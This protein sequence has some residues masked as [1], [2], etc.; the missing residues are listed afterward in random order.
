MKITPLV[1]LSAL[2]FCAIAGSAQADVYS[3]VSGL[4]FTTNDVAAFH[5]LL[6]TQQIV[7]Q[8]ILALASRE[9]TAQPTAMADTQSLDAADF[10]V[11]SDYQILSASGDANLQLVGRIDFSGRGIPTE[12]FVVRKQ[13]GTIRM[14]VLLAGE[15]G[16]GIGPLQSI[17]Q[18]LGS[19]KGLGFVIE[20]PVLSPHTF[21]PLTEA[22]PSMFRVY[23]L[24]NAGIVDVSS[25]NA[26]IFRDVIVPDLKSRLKEI[27]PPNYGDA[28]S[29]SAYNASVV[30]ITKSLELANAS[31]SATP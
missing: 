15:G 22:V 20:E 28:E 26:W 3:D 25:A 1:A 7:K 11:M 17:L 4:S 31:A 9:N 5:R 18:P 2:A 14:D 29:V 16:P 13:A 19:A 12:L 10:D 23:G 27:S 6:P 8:L 30:A 21:A 24:S